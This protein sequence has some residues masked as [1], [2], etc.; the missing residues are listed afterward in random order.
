LRVLLFIKYF[1]LF[2]ADQLMCGGASRAIHILQERHLVVL[3][4]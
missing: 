2:L 1:L 3:F 4:L